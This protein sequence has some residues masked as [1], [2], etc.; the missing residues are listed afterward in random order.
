MKLPIPI[1][2]SNVNL[3]VNTVV[4]YQDDWRQLIADIIHVDTQYQITQQA[5]RLACQHIEDSDIFQAEG[6]IRK[7]LDK[8]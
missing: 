4:I 5:L 3:P 7:I 2:F 8:V 1:E 6:M